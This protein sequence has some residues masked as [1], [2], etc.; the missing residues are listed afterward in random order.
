VTH[1]L[2]N[3]KSTVC[4]KLARLLNTRS[5]NRAK[6]EEGRRKKEEGR[7]KKEEG[8]RKNYPDS[9]LLFFKVYF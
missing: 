3:G 5:G 1:G 9:I 6:K 8:R 2:K 4:G 7:R